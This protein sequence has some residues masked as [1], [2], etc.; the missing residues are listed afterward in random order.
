[1][2]SYH[3]VAVVQT[4]DGGQIVIYIHVDSMYVYMYTCIH[5]RQGSLFIHRKPLGN[6]VQYNA[7]I[8]LSGILLV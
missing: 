6:C 3:P 7:Y 2:T 4:T 5:V 8:M 1:M